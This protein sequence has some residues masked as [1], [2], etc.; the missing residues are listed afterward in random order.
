MDNFW[1]PAHSRT[2]T[3]VR[4]SGRAVLSIEYKDYQIKKAD[5]VLPAAGN[6]GRMN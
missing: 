3:E 4:F 6:T 2:E 1:L 5:Q